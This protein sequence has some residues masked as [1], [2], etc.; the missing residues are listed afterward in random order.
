ML[1][2]CDVWLPAENRVVFVSAN[3]ESA[4]LMTVNIYNSL[5]DINSPCEE[6]WDYAQIDFEYYSDLTDSCR[7]FDMYTAARLE[8]Y[9]SEY[10][11]YGH[12]YEVL[13][14]QLP[15]DLYKMIPP[16]YRVWLEDNEEYTVL[17]NGDKIF[18]S[19][20]FLDLFK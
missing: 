6:I 10:A 17:T 14:N 18:Y 16:Y 1:E 5:V 4:A 7:F 2:V 12:R 15:D 19:D 9:R 11:M 3:E 8:F 20:D 13:I